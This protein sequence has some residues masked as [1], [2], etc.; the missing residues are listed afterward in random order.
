LRNIAFLKHIAVIVSVMLF[1]EQAVPSEAHA[2]LPSVASSPIVY[3]T[4]LLDR[5]EI[6][7][8]FAKTARHYS[9]TRDKTVLLI[10][11]AHVHQA[12]QKS[13]AGALTYFVDHH[14]LKQVYVEGADGD[15]DTEMYSFF[16]NKKAL[17]HVAN[18]YLDQGRLTGAEFASIV[19]RP[20]LKL[21]GIEDKRLYEKNRQAYLEVLET[22]ENYSELIQGFE[23]VMKQLSRFILPEDL[24]ELSHRRY[25]GQDQNFQNYARYIIDLCRKQKISLKAYPSIQEYAELGQGESDINEAMAK[26]E[27]LHLLNVSKRSFPNRLKKCGLMDHR[28]SIFLI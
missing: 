27:F 6:P 9:G 10:Q 11:D 3:Q 1:F 19:I 18:Y 8:Q 4:P 16:P 28:K 22:K 24:R 17:S 13:I 14:Q 2:A 26:K 21:Q 23:K 25:E 12:A 7:E 20:K 5:F 15:L